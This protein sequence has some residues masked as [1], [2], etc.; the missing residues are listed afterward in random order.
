MYSKPCITD[1][2]EVTEGQ[3]KKRCSQLA[4]LPNYI[5][6]EERKDIGWVTHNFGNGKI[7]TFL[8]ALDENGAAKIK[9]NQKGAGSF[10]FV[11]PPAPIV[12]ANI[13]PAKSGE[14]SY[15]DGEFKGGRHKQMIFLQNPESEENQFDERFSD[16]QQ[17]FEKITHL[18]N[19]KLPEHFAYG[20][21]TDDEWVSDVVK[22][23]GEKWETF[24]KKK[25]KGTASEKELVKKYVSEGLSKAEAKAKV[26]E[27]TG[28]NSHVDE[29]ELRT[30]FCEMLKDI[31]GKITIIVAFLTLTHVESIRV[32]VR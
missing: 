15:K 2:C 32:R 10:P 19:E 25:S 11:L 26:K 27:M 21:T 23:I 24:R 14:F 8:C 17:A 5:F 12:K 30:E 28:D 13:S 7:Q 6:N 16:W 20:K 31:V 1:Y 4:K 22:P 18:Y 9:P 3:L 29:M